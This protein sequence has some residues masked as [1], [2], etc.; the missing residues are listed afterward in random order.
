MAVRSIGF[1]GLGNMGGRMTRRLVSAGLTVLG[2]DVRSDV[3]SACGSFCHCPIAMPSRRWWA[4][5]RV[6]WRIAGPGR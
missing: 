5:P 1:V 6:S 2:F 4:G 3:V